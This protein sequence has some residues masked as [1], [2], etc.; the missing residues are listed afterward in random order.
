MKLD[1]L[2]VWTMLDQLS[3]A[4][5]AAFAQQM[6]QLGYSALWQPEGFGRNMLVQSSWLLANTSKL[7]IATGIVNVYARDAIA[8]AGAQY[9]LAEQSQGR[10][11]LG[12]GVSHAPAVS[13]MR[14]HHYGKP[15]ATMRE[16]LTAMRTHQY[17]AALPADR[18]PTVIAALGPKMLE[19]S[20]ELA[21]GAHPY[22]VTPE[23]TARARSIIGPDKLLCVEQKVIFESDPVTARAAGRKQLALYLVLENY[24]KNWASLGF[25]ESDWAGSGSDRLID[26]MFAWGPEDTIRERIRQHLDAGAD[27][28]CIQPIAPS[29]DHAQDMAVL[30]V[31][32]PARS[33]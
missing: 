16:Y 9:G 19:L 31:L 22:N 17:Q 32:A 18:P 5:S 15:V 10:F 28:V 1:K 29:G 27:Q 4:E 25:D 12:M 26:A 23:H 13:G 11:L 21:D 33:S 20:A 7:I 2:A 24:Q 3:S 6:E 14:G 8:M 30:E